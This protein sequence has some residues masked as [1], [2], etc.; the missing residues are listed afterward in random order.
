MIEAGGVV[1]CVCRQLRLAGASLSSR[2]PCAVKWCCALA[3]GIRW[4]A[5]STCPQSN[6]LNAACML[7]LPDRPWCH[8]LI[9]QYVSMSPSPKQ[10]VIQVIKYSIV[11]S[12]SARTPGNDNDSGRCFYILLTK[13]SVGI[14]LWSCWYHVVQQMQVFVVSGDVSSKPARRLREQDTGLNNSKCSKHNPGIRIEFPSSFGLII[15]D[16]EYV[17]LVATRATL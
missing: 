15:D 1:E 17:I 16:T 9:Q 10:P 3:C 5:V 4:K 6:L 7:R 2:S 12:L 13:Q 14:M 11:C 8:V